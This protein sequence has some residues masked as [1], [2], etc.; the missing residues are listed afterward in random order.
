MSTR[1]I[2]A[3]LLVSTGCGKKQPPQPA[4]PIAAEPAAVPATG[5]A[6]EQTPAAREEDIGATTS[7]LTQAVRKFAAEQRR[8][9]KSLDDLVAMGYLPAVPSA[10]GGKRFAINKNLEVYL[11]K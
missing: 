9:P 8:A 7:Q 11:E 1:V 10:P 6:P 4:T 3:C 5:A 2:L